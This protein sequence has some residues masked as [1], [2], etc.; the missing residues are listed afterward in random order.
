MADASHAALLG[1]LGKLCI[2]PRQVDTARLGLA[3]SPTQVSWAHK[4]LAVAS[5]GEARA[6]SGS[7]VDRPVEERA[8][9]ILRRAMIEG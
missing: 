1:F 5:N 9:D 4:I 7:M 3:P 8:R 6:F 2:H